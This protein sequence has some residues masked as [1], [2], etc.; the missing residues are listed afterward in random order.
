MYMLRRDEMKD[1]VLTT[2][3]LTSG[4]ATVVTTSSDTGYGFRPG[5]SA[6]DAVRK[7]KDY[8]DEGYRYVVDLDLASFFDTV[9]HSRLV[10]RLSERVKDGRVI[11]LVHK[12][13]NAGVMVDGVKQKTERGVP[14]GWP[15]SPILSNIVLDELDKELERRG[16]RFVRYSDDCMIFAKSKRAAERVRGSITRYIEEKLRLRVNEEK[17]SVRSVFSHAFNNDALSR[18]GY[19]SLVHSYDLLTS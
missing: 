6:H 15:L 17:T 18:Q 11:S 9:N 8:I 3:G 19:P 1:D 10:R 16:L 7:A 13:L 2:G 5:R 14:Q 12:Y 4:F